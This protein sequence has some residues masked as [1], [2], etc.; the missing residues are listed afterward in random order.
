MNDYISGMYTTVA[1]ARMLQHKL[2]TTP[3]DRAQYEILSKLCLIIQGEIKVEEQK[4]KEYE[5]SQLNIP[6]AVN[7]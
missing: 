7:S 2:Q 3:F 1:L 5:A 4:Q 6:F